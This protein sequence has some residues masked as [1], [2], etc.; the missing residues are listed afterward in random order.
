VALNLAGLTSDLTALF[1]SPPA[2]RELCAQEWADAMASYASAVVPASTTVAAAS[3]TL[4]TS[5]ATAFA[6]PSAAAQMETAFTAWATTVGSG[7]AAA[8]WTGAPPPG[9]VGFATLAGT[10]P[11][12]HADAAASF[13]GLINTWALTGTAVLIAPPN[14]PVTW[15]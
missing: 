3:A 13:A 8:G 10:Q 5:L 6:Q 4:A 1:A 15:T 2:T 12:T 7:M 9:A 14:T 11:A